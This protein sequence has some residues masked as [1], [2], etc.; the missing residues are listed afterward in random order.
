M[1]AF[2]IVLSVLG[3]TMEEALN[4]NLL[5]PSDSSFSK[6]CWDPVFNLFALYCYIQCACFFPMSWSLQI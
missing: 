3:Q 4:Y 1:V 5:V 2:S 6:Q